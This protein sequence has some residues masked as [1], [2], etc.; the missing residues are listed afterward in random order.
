M[1]SPI[2]LEIAATILHVIIAM[3]TENALYRTNPKG[4]ITP[5]NTPLSN[6]LSLKG[7]EFLLD[8]IRALVSKICVVR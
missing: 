4:A 3:L 5:K 1:L 8:Y 2:L 7:R 6:I